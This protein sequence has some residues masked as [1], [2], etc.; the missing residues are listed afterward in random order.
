[1]SESQAGKVHD[2]GEHQTA[3]VAMEKLTESAP[4][5]IRV[6][7]PRQGRSKE[8][9]QCMADLRRSI[10]FGRSSRVQNLRR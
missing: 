1:V 2:R 7:Q 10:W 6:R 4:E 8:V 5:K 3:D 9:S